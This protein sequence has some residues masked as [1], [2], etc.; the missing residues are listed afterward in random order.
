MSARR[1]SCEV[2]RPSVGDTAAPTLEYGWARSL[3]HSTVWV[4]SST[5][6]PPIRSASL[7]TASPLMMTPNVSPPSRATTPPLT[8][9]A[10]RCATAES[11]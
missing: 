3:F 6:R 10:R 1:I 5:I 2:S 4:R 9:V 11:T 7:V 8:P